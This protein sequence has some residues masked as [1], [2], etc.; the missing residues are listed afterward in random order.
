MVEIQPFRIIYFVMVKDNAHHWLNEGL[1][2]TWTM[3]EQGS[4]LWTFVPLRPFFGWYPI[5]DTTTPYGKPW[6]GSTWTMRNR[7]QNNSQVNSR[8]AKKIIIKF[9]RQTNS[10]NSRRNCWWSYSTLQPEPIGPD[11]KLWTHKSMAWSIF[12]TTYYPLQQLLSSERLAQ[13]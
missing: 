1:V 7:K 2:A 3:F 8:I 12:P 11:P 10:K 5:S 6:W 13:F 9:K 4:I